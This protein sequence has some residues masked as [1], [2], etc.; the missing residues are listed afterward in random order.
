MPPSAARQQIADHGE[1][2][3]DA[4]VGHLEPG[5]RRHA[6]DDREG[7]AI[8]QP[9]STSRR[10]MRP[11]LALDNSRVASARTATVM[12][13]VAA[14]PPWLATIGAS[15]A[16]ATIFC[17]SP[18]NRPSTEEA[19]KAVARLTS[20]QLN[21]PRAMVQTGSD[22][23][24]SRRDAA[25]RLDVLLRL[26]LDHVD[27]VVEGD[28]ADQPVALVDHRG[29]DQIVALEQARHVLLVVGGADRAQL[30]VDQLRD[31]HRPLGPQQPV[32]RD[33]ALQS[34]APDRRRRVPRSGPADRASR[35]YGRWSVPRSMPAAPR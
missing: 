30:L 26:L 29:G 4:E 22:S 11:A 1:T 17:S 18:S 16:S 33:R 24:S 14:L 35:A 12:V 34:A 25:Q 15:T 2:D 6:G 23:S 10:M 27:D 19:R 20:S 21:R 32:E 9:T 7:Q 3:D 5:R 31:R 8:D 13:W 28:H